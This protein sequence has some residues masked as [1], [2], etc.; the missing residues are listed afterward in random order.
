M[1]SLATLLLTPV[2][3]REE[4]QT[5]RHSAELSSR[6]V[7]LF[8]LSLDRWL[9]PPLETSFGAWISRN[10]GVHCAFYSS[11]DS[12]CEEMCLFMRQGLTV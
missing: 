5:H 7:P 11:T 6:P 12:G 1:Q 10:C 2:R 8:L 3:V 9:L 4:L